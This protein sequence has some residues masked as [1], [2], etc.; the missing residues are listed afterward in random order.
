MAF[1]SGSMFLVQKCKH[2][3]GIK[4]KIRALC[5]H[6]SQT[7]C[8]LTADELK[9]KDI[10]YICQYWHVS[11]T[12]SFLSYRLLLS[13]LHKQIAPLVISFF[14]LWIKSFLYISQRNVTV[15]FK[16]DNL[17]FF[18]L[19]RRTHYIYRQSAI[20]NF[21][22]KKLVQTPQSENSSIFFQICFNYHYSFFYFFN[23]SCF[24]QTAA[25]T[26][27]T[28]YNVQKAVHVN[29]LLLSTS[30][31]SELWTNIFDINMT[32]QLYQTWNIKYL[33]IIKIYW[34]WQ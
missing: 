10:I 2:N 29:Y 9:N 27:I 7:V 12:I 26:R 15:C 20:F 5:P 32:P 34:R 14:W 30:Y 6:I 31:S 17:H 13:Q 11:L 16:I 28:V 33:V 4:N 8:S 3:I 22:H 21:F 24:L 25:N 19:S 1:Y 23:C 18:H